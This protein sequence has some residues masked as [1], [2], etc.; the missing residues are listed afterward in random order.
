MILIEEKRDLF[1]LDNTYALCHCI[2]SD[3]K[4]GAGIAVKFREMGVVPKLVHQCQGKRW[5]GVGYCLYTH[6][7]DDITVFNLVTKERYFH[8]PTYETLKQSLIDL[9]WIVRL[10]SINRLAMPRIGCGLDKLNWNKVSDIINE[11]F[12]DIDDLEIRVCYL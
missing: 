7:K 3:F 6:L 9:K 10:L 2:S 11:V 1:S 5:D 12:N 4:L 8:K